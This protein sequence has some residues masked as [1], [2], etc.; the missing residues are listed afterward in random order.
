MK[1]P[2]I[3]SRLCGFR[4]ALLMA[5]ASPFFGAVISPVIA[6]DIVWDFGAAAGTASPVSQPLNCAVSGLTQGNNNTVPPATTPAMLSAGSA[7]GAT[8]RN[9]CCFESK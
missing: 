9:S 6:E 1:R 3:H 7:T 8:Y 5:V 2:S 4:T